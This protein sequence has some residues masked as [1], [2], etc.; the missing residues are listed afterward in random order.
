[1]T[2]DKFLSKYNQV[3]SRIEAIEK[4]FGLTLLA[5]IVLSICL[6]VLTRAVWNKS[7][8]WVEELCTYGF[9]WAAFLGAA[10]GTKHQRHIKIST[11]LFRLDYKKQ[12]IIAEIS[13]ALMLLI[14]FLIVQNATGLYKIETRSNIIAIPFLPRFYVFSLP[15]LVSLISMIITIPYLMLNDY[16]AYRLEGEKK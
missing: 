3:L 15:L 16:M 11:F 6:Q 8:I 7:Q 1:M 12:L 2:L 5:F 9:I 10:I 13:Y 14:L 4:F